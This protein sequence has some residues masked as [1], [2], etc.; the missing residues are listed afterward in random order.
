MLRGIKIVPV[1]V[2]VALDWYL[3]YL[4]SFF[5]G[6]FIASSYMGSQHGPEA[7]R[8]Q[9]VREVYTPTMAVVGSLVGAASSV[10]GGFIAGWMAKGERIKNG[11]AM[12]IL[13]ALTSGLLVH[14]TQHPGF[15]QEV[16]GNS[17]TVLAGA[18]GG[19]LAKLAY[20]RPPPVA[21]VQP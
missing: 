11:V 17:V 1:I 3:T 12:G 14:F 7:N 18:L 6:I 5:L 2:G 20:D 13:S 16:V 9:M 8:A 15:V 19:F 10:L 21:R 4:L